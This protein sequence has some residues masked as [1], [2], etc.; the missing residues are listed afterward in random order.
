MQVRSQEGNHVT[1]LARNHELT[2][3]KCVGDNNGICDRCLNRGNDVAWQFVGCKRG[4]L[5]NQVPS[6]ILCPKQT[7]YQ[8]SQEA[9]R[10]EDDGI[11]DKHCLKSIL[12]DIS[13]GLDRPVI[14]LHG[15]STLLDISALL[16]AATEISNGSPEHVSMFH[17][18]RII[19]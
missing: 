19:H 3:N 16:E 7:L 11:S 10:L 9:T 4:Q 6:I 1:L 2:W 8:H 13:A 5:D 15:A 18:K 12:L 14:S 17:L